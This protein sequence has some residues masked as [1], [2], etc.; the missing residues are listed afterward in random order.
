MFSEWCSLRTRHRDRDGYD[1]RQNIGTGVRT[2]LLV[3]G[4]EISCVFRATGVGSQ[5]TFDRQ[6][7]YP[8]L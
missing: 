6:S 1:E 7:H 5:C 2:V 3:A 4:L 8:A